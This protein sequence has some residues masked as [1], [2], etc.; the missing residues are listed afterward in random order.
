MARHPTE[1]FG[2]GLFA[3]LCVFGFLEMGIVVWFG[4]RADVFDRDVHV[5][6]PG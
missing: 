6:I 5:K 1:I 2:L 4:G 3:L